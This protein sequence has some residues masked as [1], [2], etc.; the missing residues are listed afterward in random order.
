MKEC[1]VNAYHTCMNCHKVFKSRINMTKH[2]RIQH[3]EGKFKCPKED[4]DFVANYR[5]ELVRHRSNLHGKMK[6]CP[7]EECGLM[8]HSAVFQ[9]HMNRHYNIKNHLC[10]WPECGKAFVDRKSLKDHIRIHVGHKRFKCKWSECGYAAEQ[11][12]NVI[13]HIR[14][15]HFKLPYTLK[16]QK[17]LNITSTQRPQDYLEVLP[18]DVAI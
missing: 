4:C 11:R 5:A 17:E 13:K 6:K 12:S 9:S 15:K 3:V 14:I 7:V 2:H 16:E 18:D 10:S 1:H 8:V